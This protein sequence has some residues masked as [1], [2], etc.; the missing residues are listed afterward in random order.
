V[1]EEEENEEGGKEANNEETSSSFDS[2][3]ETEHVLVENGI[4]PAKPK[5]NVEVCTSDDDIVIEEDGSYQKPIQ[6]VTVSARDV[7]K[8]SEPCVEEVVEKEPMD[9]ETFISVNE[10]SK[11][12]QSER[13]VSEVMEME[14]N[15]PHEQ[16]NAGG[17]PLVMGQHMIDFEAEITASQISNPK[18]TE[19]TSDCNTQTHVKNQAKLSEVE[20]KCIAS[21]KTSEMS[22]GEGKQGGK[23]CDLIK[24]EKEQIAMEEK[25]MQRDGNSAVQLLCTESIAKPLQ[26]DDVG[27]MEITVEVEEEESLVDKTVG[28][29][30]NNVAAQQVAQEMDATRHGTEAGK[31]SESLSLC[32]DKLQSTS[33]LEERTQNVKPKKTN[34]RAS[35]V[36]REVIHVDVATCT[37]DVELSKADDAAT[38]PQHT[39]SEMSNESCVQERESHR[40]CVTAGSFQR[41]E[42]QKTEACEGEVGKLRSKAVPVSE[43]DSDKQKD[44]KQSSSDETELH[45]RKVCKPSSRASSVQREDVLSDDVETRGRKVRKSSS[46][47]SSVQREDVLSDDIETCGRKAHKSSSRAGS[48]QRED[49]LSNDIE[50]HGRKVH[51]SSSRAGSVQHEDVLSDEVETRGRKVRKSSSRPSSVQREDVLSDDIETYGRKVHK[52]SSRAGS[53][54]RE[55]VLSDEVETLG[56]KV[57]KSSSRASSV[58]HEDVPS[59]ETESHERKIRRRS[60]RASSVQCEDVPS[61]ET[62]SHERKVCRRSSRASSV[63]HE[64]VPSDEVELH[65]R[66][67]SRAGSVHREVVPTDETECS[68]RKICKPSSRTGSVEQDVLTDGTD[69]NEREV[70]K[71]SSRGYLVQQQVAHSSET[72]SLESRVGRHNCRV[73]SL[74]GNHLEVIEEKDYHNSEVD[75]ASNGINS[76]QP[77]NTHLEEADSSKC[78]IDEAKK[79]SSVKCIDVMEADSLDRPNSRVSSVDHRDNTLV[80]DFA[81]N[82][83]RYPTTSSVSSEASTVIREESLHL[84]GH[85]KRRSARGRHSSVSSRCS[86]AQSDEG[87]AVEDVKIYLTRSRQA[88]YSQQDTNLDVLYEGPEESIETVAFK[89]TEIDNRSGSEVCNIVEVTVERPHTGSGEKVIDNSERKMEKKC[90]HQVGSSHSKFGLN[91][92]SSSGVKHSDLEDPNV[93]IEDDSLT[94]TLR[95]SKAVRSRIKKTNMSGHA[96][97]TESSELSVVHDADLPVQADN[98]K[99]KKPVLRRRAISMSGLEDQG[100]SGPS[101]L[102]SEVFSFISTETG[103]PYMKTKSESRY[104]VE[105]ATRKK[106][107]T[108]SALSATD[109]GSLSDNVASRS[110]IEQ[111]RAGCFHGMS[112]SVYG[113]GSCS[114]RSSGSNIQWKEKAGSANRGD[115]SS[116]Q[117]VMEEYATNRR[118]TRRQ[119]SMLE[120]SLELTK[121]QESQVTR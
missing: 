71:S 87:M 113:D 103:E 30:A 46:R 12:G 8:S 2:G 66:G 83:N 3:S 13:Q 5:V 67:V 120:R 51:K 57:R 25:L 93:E 92:R 23:G 20:E 48:V 17:E 58:Q 22:I 26:Q 119:R 61:D 100:I 116:T 16:D 114:D 42:T 69:D 64:N 50:T 38:I 24:E 65:D 36:Q 117:Q 104:V 55:G 11:R 75:K 41:E 89:E 18:H 1:E 96:H 6:V 29:S 27:V 80:A 19:D 82:E 102:K 84:A 28:T 47:A 53:V 62:E 121:L 73:G 37:W 111:E 81:F 52:S 109:I 35:S 40:V 86:S 97:D 49:V 91:T 72:E 118:L 39:I 105:H 14:V 9:F 31:T 45:E 60:S 115:S 85:T 33:N 76:V 43:A 106:R 54:Q 101:L 112:R 32:V 74:Q 107:I 98:N 90:S 68:E 70:H 59:D 108:R 7:S 34:S 44:R 94:R 4:V 99:E 78:R 95:E 88:G 110:D 63:Q 56:R 15:L 79:S 21:P 77:V 10:I